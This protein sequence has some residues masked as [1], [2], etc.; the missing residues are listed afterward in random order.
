MPS[1]TEL[2]SKR[3]YSQINIATTNDNAYINTIDICEG[4][5]Y[6]IWNSETIYCPAN[7]TEPNIVRYDNSLYKCTHWQ[8]GTSP[9]RDSNSGWIWIQDCIEYPIY[10]NKGNIFP[11]GNITAFWLYN[12][13]IYIN[14]LYGYI[15]NN[16]DI[17]DINDN[18]NKIPFENYD[19][20][21]N[22]DTNFRNATLIIRFCDDLRDEYIINITFDEYDI[23]ND[24]ITWLKQ[25]ESFPKIC[26]LDNNN[27][28]DKDINKKNITWIVLIIIIS[29]IV[30]ACMWLCC[31]KS[32]GNKPAGFEETQLLHVDD[33][34]TNKHY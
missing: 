2:Q 1:Q 9:N 13:S 16:I 5:T 24:N 26:G 11:Y 4:L 19:L 21:V 8:R 6:E 33:K 29:C 34:G 15:I 25:Y 32:N 23:Q 20:L 7:F 18:T 12:L 30:I 27:D 22:N 3:V 17:P 28:N 14:P 10:F 31:K